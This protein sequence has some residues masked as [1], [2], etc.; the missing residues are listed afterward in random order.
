MSVTVT[1]LTKLADVTKIS[2]SELKLFATNYDVFKSS[3]VKDRDVDSTCDE[4]WV[5]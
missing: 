4:Q 2:R 5:T 1:S 3:L